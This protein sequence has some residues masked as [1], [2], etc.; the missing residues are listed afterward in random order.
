MKKQTTKWSPDTCDC[1]LVYGWDSDDQSKEHKFL[2]AEKLCAHHKGLASKD[3]YDKVL[4]ENKRKNRAWKIARDAGIELDDF[5]FSFDDNRK[6]KVGFLGKLNSAQKAE[7][8][9]QFDNEFGAN[10]AEVI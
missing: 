9:A 4:D 5:T 7:L 8:Q 2:R 1:V 3:A 6:L 10:K